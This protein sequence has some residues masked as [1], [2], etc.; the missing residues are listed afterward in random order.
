MIN[1]NVSGSEYVNVPT[2]NISS[3]CTSSRG[4]III[5][6][7]IIIMS[8]G[9]CSTGVDFI[10]SSRNSVFVDRI[11]FCCTYKNDKKKISPSEQIVSFCFFSFEHK[12]LGGYFP[13]PTQRFLGVI[14]MRF[15][16]S[17]HT[18]L[19]REVKQTHH[20]HA[21]CEWLKPLLSGSGT[22]CE[23]VKVILRECYF[24][25]GNRYLVASTRN[26]GRLC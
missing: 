1:V 21:I 10:S 2:N 3:W 20:C 17:W 13:I 16:I 12:Y 23:T 11:G 19:R 18:S 24:A 4:T 6:I 22:K 26:L 9:I 14:R 8:R 5:I 7:I 15:S 25:E